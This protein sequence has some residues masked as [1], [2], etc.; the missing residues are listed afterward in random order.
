[1]TST[2]SQGNSDFADELKD[3]I[4]TDVLR[5]ALRDV[6]D[7]DE[8]LR[9]LVARRHELGLNQTTVA[10]RMESGQST[11]SEFEN[12][13]ADPYFSTLQRYARAV[14]AR[15]AVTLEL[16]EACKMVPIER[17]RQLRA[18]AAL[19]YETRQFEMKPAHAV[20]VRGR[21]AYGMRGT[22]GASAPRPISQ[23]RERMGTA[24]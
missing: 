13:A 2:H 20:V 23:Y 14:D 11:V 10:V 4:D 21:S 7:R 8:L 5:D 16:D 24:S 22:A 19:G 6:E 12:G 17:G 15:I 18:T 1:M 3:L 9:A